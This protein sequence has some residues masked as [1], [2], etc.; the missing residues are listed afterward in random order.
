VT[1]CVAALGKVA[2][3]ALQVSLASD[4]GHA[5]IA[6]TARLGPASLAAALIGRQLA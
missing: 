5:R 2:R 3:E 6:Q 1:A 4:C